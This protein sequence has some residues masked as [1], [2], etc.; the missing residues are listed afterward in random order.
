MHDPY[1]AFL[2]LMNGSTHFCRSESWTSALQ[3]DVIFLT[4]YVPSARK[5]LLMYHLPVPRVHPSISFLLSYSKLWL[6]FI[7]TKDSNFFIVLSMNIV[8]NP[9]FLPQPRGYYKE[10]IFW[11]SCVTMILKET[12]NNIFFLFLVYFQNAG[13]LSFFS[14]IFYYSLFLAVVRPMFLIN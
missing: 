8:F 1:P 11:D 4:T 7:R 9:L 12:L 5:F 6:S 14:I 3:A 2:I 13:S 10:P